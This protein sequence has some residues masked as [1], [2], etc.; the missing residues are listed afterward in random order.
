MTRKFN[1]RMIRGLIAS[2]NGLH[3]GFKGDGY[4]SIEE[5]DS[6]WYIGGLPCYLSILFSLM[7]GHCDGCAFFL[8]H[9]NG[10]LVIEVLFL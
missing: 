7:W 10:E 9:R 2:L 3:D 5:T 6:R 4:F 1:E 8:E